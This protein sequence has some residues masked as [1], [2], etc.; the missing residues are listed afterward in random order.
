MRMD[1][2]SKKIDSHQYQ[3]ERLQEKIKILGETAWYDRQLKWTEVEDWLNQFN[4]QD[5]EK[6]HFLHLLSN[7]MYF[8][9]REVRE[10]LRSLYRDI[11]RSPTIRSIRKKHKNTKDFNLLNRLYDDE[12]QKTRFLGIGNPSESGTHLLYLFRQINALPKKLFIHGH[13]IYRRNSNGISDLKDSTVKRY[14]FL[15]DLTGTGSQAIQ[16]SEDLVQIIKDL[17]PEITVDYYVLF[18][19]VEAVRRIQKHTLFNDVRAVFLLDE[20][21][22]CFSDHSRYFKDS[23]ECPNRKRSLELCKHYDKPISKLICQKEGYL[24]ESYY[25]LGFK[26]SQLL[27][28]FYHNTPDNV[29]PIFWYDSKSSDPFHWKS[30]F[31]RF[32]KVY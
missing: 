24:N 25:E 10:M 28:G 18:A 22:K 2:S 3:L 23:N 27:L 17:K 1:H 4:N 13:Q 19:T 20:S 29:P 32:H 30:I 16:Y 7:F 21:F 12:L 9:I 5:S 11:Y 31:A 8:G 15:D 6:L 14:V 26:E